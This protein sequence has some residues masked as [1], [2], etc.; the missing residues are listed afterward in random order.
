MGG[1]TL[2]CAKTLPSSCS[3]DR[4]RGDA[5]ICV[6]MCS[7]TDR[8]R[9]QKC[10]VKRYLNSRFTFRR[11]ALRVCLGQLSLLSE[12]KSTADKREK[13]ATVWSVTIGGRWRDDSKSLPA[14]P[15]EGS[16]PLAHSAGKLLYRWSAL[17]LCL[18]CFKCWPAHPSL[19]K[20]AH[21]GQALFR[22]AGVSFLKE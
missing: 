20:L 21:K 16:I 22:N 4:Q 6:G 5:V 17:A 10:G 12:L 1:R 19:E 9:C 13:E 7:R 14:N 8:T 11:E 2:L 18:S 15:W 3:A